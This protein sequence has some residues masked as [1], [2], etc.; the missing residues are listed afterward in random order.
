[1]KIRPNAA[2]LLLGIALCVGSNAGAKTRA[3]QGFDLII[4]RHAQTVANVTKDYSPENQRTFSAQGKAEV[5]ELAHKLRALDIDHV[6]VS[7][8]HRTLHTIA[9][10]LESE[11]EVAEVW[12]E[13]EECCYHEDRDASASATIPPGHPIEIDTALAPLFR[14]RSPE[15]ARWYNAQNYADSEKMALG[16]AGL[17]ERRFGGT[18]KTVLVVTHC[19]TGAWMI[20]ELLGDPEARTI[21]LGTAKV[22]RLRQGPDGRYRL[23]SL[24]EKPFEGIY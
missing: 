21:V 17:L 7:P 23:L 9:T 5:R 8:T 15:A 20:A 2:A 3:A 22:S 12:P 10:Y 14:F 1:M 19:H 16:A 13:V 4:V 24:N 11:G 18:G 6:V